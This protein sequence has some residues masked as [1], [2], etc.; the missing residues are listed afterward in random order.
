MKDKQLMFKIK[1]IYCISKN[2]TLF[3]QI[4]IVTMDF[5]LAVTFKIL[6]KNT[7]FL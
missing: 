5:V 7:V 4:N 1:L 3:K 2:L 6:L